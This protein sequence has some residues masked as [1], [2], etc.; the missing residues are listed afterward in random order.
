MQFIIYIYIILLN[1][2]FCRKM[3]I[4]FDL[5][6]AILCPIM[7]YFLL[8][9]HV[10][11]HQAEN[12]AVKVE[13]IDLRLGNRSTPRVLRFCRFTKMQ[14]TFKL[15]DERSLLELFLNYIVYKRA[16]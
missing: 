5:F 14:L 6:V 15:L 16:S 1:I 12:D 9:H 2:I 11:S 13:V 10:S 7:T 8:K 4:S 3:V